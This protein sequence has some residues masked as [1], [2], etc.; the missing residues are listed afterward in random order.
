MLWTAFLII[1][2]MGFVKDVTSM[3]IIGA[4]GMGACTITSS[5]FLIYEHVQYE[6]RLKKKIELTNDIN[7]KLYLLGRR[8]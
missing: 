5:A 3:I 8:D 1:L 6:K 4:I 7:F 2:I